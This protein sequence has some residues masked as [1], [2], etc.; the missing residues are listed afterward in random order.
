MTLRRDYYCGVES[1]M[2]DKFEENTPD[3]LDDDTYERVTSIIVRV[4]I[5]T[6]NRTIHA[7]LSSNDDDDSVFIACGVL[8]LDGSSCEFDGICGSLS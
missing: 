7:L 6:N 3:E 5:T 4:N 2:D 8:S 1:L